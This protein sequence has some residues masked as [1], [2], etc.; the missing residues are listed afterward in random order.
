MNKIITIFII[1][2]LLFSLTGCNINIEPE[3]KKSNLL[4]FKSG[5][6][7]VNAFKDFQDNYRST[8]MY[9]M[10]SMPAK[11]ETVSGAG[12][13]QYSETNIQVEGVDEA[14]IVKT[15]GDY[16][17]YIVQNKLIIVKAY[18]A[19][20]AKIVSETEFKDFYPSELFIDNDKLLI[21]V[22]LII[23]L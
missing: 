8:R 1:G 13:N 9:D 4:K 23:M 16:I 20:E 15:D 12:E 2:I 6:E 10:V 7:L 14:D 3:P 19:D 17:Y 11:A 18:P 22:L 21:L 5:N